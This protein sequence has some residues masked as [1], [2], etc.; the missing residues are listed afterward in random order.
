VRGV[1]LA[2]PG[3]EEGTSYGTPAFRVRGK[4]FVLVR[5]SKA[6][7]AVLAEALENSWR[8]AAPRRL[9]AE[10]DDAP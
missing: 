8:R 7:R 6:S 5:V 3:V 9:L 4:F 1:A 10:F 2:L